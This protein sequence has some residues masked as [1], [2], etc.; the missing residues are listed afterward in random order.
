MRRRLR[1]SQSSDPLRGAV[2]LLAAAVAAWRGWQIHH[3]CYALLAYGLA[4]LALAMGIWHLTRRPP[5]ERR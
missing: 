1:G 2:M 5:Q 3:G 4:V